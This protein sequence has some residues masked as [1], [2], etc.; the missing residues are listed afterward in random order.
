MRTQIKRTVFLLLGLL[1]LDYTYF[2]WLPYP[3]GIIVP[4]FEIIPNAQEYV[5]RV[6]FYL[7]YF[8][9]IFLF[10]RYDSSAYFLLTKPRKLLKTGSVLL[11]CFGLR[12]VFDAGLIAVQALWGWRHTAVFCF[13]DTLFTLLLFWWMRRPATVSVPRRKIL[14]VLCAAF[15][16]VTGFLYYRAAQVDAG[17]IYVHEKYAETTHRYIY[18][19]EQL[20]FQRQVTFIACAMATHVF[21]MGIGLLHKPKT[22][23]KQLKTT[24]DRSVDT[25]RLVL[26]LF[27]LLAVVGIK[28]FFL[29]SSTIIVRGWE[30]LNSDTLDDVYYYTKT[31]GT[32]RYFIRVDAYGNERK[33]EYS[34]PAPREL[35]KW[36]EPLT[37][38]DDPGSYSFYQVEVNDQKIVSYGPLAVFIPTDNGLQIIKKEEIRDLPYHELLIGFLKNRVSAGDMEWY[39]TGLLYLLEHDKDFIMDY[40]SRYA[41]GE[42]SE[43]ERKSMVRME[44]VQRISEEA[45]LSQPGGPEK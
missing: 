5:S 11:P 20:D 8:L 41:A 38:V 10:E 36:N 44:F 40:V 22:H 6:L 18:G 39:E 34:D 37:L 27:L 4:S 25:L 21:L 31:H 1:W 33:Y 23:S 26:L 16:I 30:S 28:P 19:R 2:R 9:W 43:K 32:T 35:G 3:R 29:P 15:V 13:I 45:L 7:I 14:Y 12:L 24:R 42:F 17:L